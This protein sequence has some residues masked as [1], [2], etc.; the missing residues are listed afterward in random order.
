M[1]SLLGELGSF[2]SG[3]DICAVK[4]LITCGSVDQLSNIETRVR[5]INFAFNKKVFFLSFCSLR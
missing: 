5:L 4:I 3:S 2:N 1:F